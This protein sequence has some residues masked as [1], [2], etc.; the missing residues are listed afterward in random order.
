MK[1]RYKGLIIN[2][3]RIKD[4]TYFGTE[5]I[6]EEND[7]LYDIAQR[8]HTTVIKLKEINS[9]KSE[10]IHP[11]QILIVDNAYNPE[12]PDLYLKYIVKNNDTIYS[13]AYNYGMTTLELKEINSELDNKIEVGETIF[14]FNRK[15]KLNSEDTYVVEKGD[16][17]YSISKKYKISIE[18]LKE[19]N[20]LKDDFLKTGME[21]IVSTPEIKKK[22]QKE[23]EIYIVMPGDCLYSIA[24]KKNTTVE[25]LKKINN[26]TDD[27]ISI[28][29]ELYLPAEED[30]ER[31]R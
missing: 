15:P 21:L 22:K 26:L 17:L 2:N 13:I 8:F 30:E 4:I 27:L 31:G 11:G 6:V 10:T 24:L 7:S 23:R 1:K 14:V 5:Y 12:R 19:I 29:Q 25:E 20:N 3:L 9:L 16:N 28:G 18:E